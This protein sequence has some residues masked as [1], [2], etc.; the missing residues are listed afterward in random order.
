[1]DIILTEG[2]I[3]KVLTSDEWEVL[4]LRRWG[5]SYI[6]IAYLT[7]MTTGQVSYRME[8][9]KAKFSPFSCKTATGR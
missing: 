2:D 9:I 1:M 3:Q 5:C 6:D 8:C 4:D 7:G